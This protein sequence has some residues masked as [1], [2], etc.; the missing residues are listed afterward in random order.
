MQGIFRALTVYEEVSLICQIKSWT[1]IQTKL[2]L[3]TTTI[4]IFPSN[5]TQECNHVY[6]A[7]IYIYICIYKYI[8]IY[9]RQEYVELYKE[10]TVFSI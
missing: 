5:N 2:A 8:Y 6:T 4:H 7:Y 3:P 10:C 9:Y 1:L